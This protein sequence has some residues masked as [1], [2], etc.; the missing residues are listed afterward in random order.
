M[1]SKDP[2]IIPPIRRRVK[3][4]NQ[5]RRRPPC[6]SRLMEQ[7]ELLETVER[8]DPAGVWQAMSLLALKSYWFFLRIVNDYRWMDP[9]FHGTELCTFLEDLQNN[10]EDGLIL[11]W[12]GGGKSGMITQPMP[13]WWLAKDPY[14]RCGIANATE[15]RAGQMIRA[16]AAIVSG[17]KL[18]QNCFP[19]VRPSSKWGEDG[20]Y[21]DTLVQQENIYG[22]H[23]RIDPSLGSYGISGNITG[24]HYNG[25]FIF[26][27]L[28]NETFSRSPKMRQRSEKFFAESINCIDPSTPVVGC[29]TRWT[30]DDY[31]GKIESGELTGPKGRFRVFKTGVERVVNGKSQIVWPR[32]TYID[33]QG[34]SVL[35]GES[36][37]SLRAKKTT[38]KY[39][40]SALYMNEPVTGD[41]V[42]FDIPKIGF[43]QTLP[44]PFE[45]GPVNKI[46]VEAESQARSIMSAFHMIQKQE[47]RKY[48]VET[49]TSKREDKKTRIRSVLQPLIADNRFM[50][51][52]DL[53]RR[54][55]SLGEEIRT[56]DKGYTDCID[57]CVYCIQSLENYQG[58]MSDTFPVVH[59]AVD[60]AFSE[61]AYSC[62]TGIVAG[63]YF[64][65]QFWALDCVRIQTDRSDYIVRMVFAMADK[66]QNLAY[67]RE[68][69]RKQLKEGFRSLGARVTNRSKRRYSSRDFYGK[70]DRS[71]EIDLSVMQRVVTE[72]QKKEQ[73]QQ[74]HS[75]QQGDVNETHSVK[76][77]LAGR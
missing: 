75:Q 57:A 58:S 67:K 39:L 12:R 33:I 6:E 14:A 13:A 44:P 3:E 9:W 50:I 7:L 55:D 48:I 69:D 53:W 29:A 8:E 43:F 52:E 2:I 71:F 73:E 62:Y 68:R 38:L 42:Q 65:N 26:D 27:D 66:F 64:Q 35:V 21:L 41:D 47:N 28:L 59:I 74:L 76:A 70:D 51:R 16:A 63:C 31:T 32:Q 60:P 23:E 18:Y 25:G 24:S 54:T 20:Y 22:S 15:S 61:A 36:E 11:V 17:N 40:Y 4:E 77:P 45:L 46:V 5:R 37:E 1:R 56:F 49:I 10:N 72:E 30:Y 34:K 19:N